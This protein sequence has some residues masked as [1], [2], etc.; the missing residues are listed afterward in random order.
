MSANTPTNPIQVTWN[1]DG[2]ATVL[3]RVTARDGS[4][5]ATGVRGE[6]NWLQQADLSSITCSVFD[7]SSETPDTAIA[8]PT[9]T[10][11]SVIVDSPVST[12]VLW[13]EDT[14]GYNFIVDLAASNFP[15][16]NNV[17][18][19]EFKFTTTG[20]AVFWGIYEGRAVPVRTS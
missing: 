1:E 10:I 7:L 13:T 11:S 16:G 5:T 8:T 9:I 20:S 3:G 4:G 2:S 14:T 17:Y 19:V 18:R 12:T 15:T 6:G